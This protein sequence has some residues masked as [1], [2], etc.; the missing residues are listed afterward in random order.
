M[1]EPDMGVERASGG[2][3]ASD[4]GDQL[5]AAVASFS[6]AMDTLGIHFAMVTLDASMQT[7]ENTVLGFVGSV[8]LSL[9]AKLFEKYLG[10]TK[11]PETR[12]RYR[13]QVRS[14]T[15]LMQ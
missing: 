9:G 7:D 8:S 1:L 10:M 2:R 4:R 15:G 14:Q 3:E 6:L 13:A 11:N 5:K 12:V